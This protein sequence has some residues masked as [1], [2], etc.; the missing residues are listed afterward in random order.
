MCDLNFITELNRLPILSF[1]GN[2][3]CD[4]PV[5]SNTCIIQ[6]YT[7]DCF[8]N[9]FNNMSSCNSFD[10]GDCNGDSFAWCLQNDNYYYAFI[11]D[12]FVGN[13]ACTNRYA[14]EYPNEACPTKLYRNCFC[15][16]FMNTTACSYDGG[17][18]NGQTFDYCKSKYPRIINWT[19]Y[20]YKK[21]L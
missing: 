8:C 17:D 10:G 2:G 18:C 14:N 16:C 21:N 15:D 12:T 11:L 13:G 4:E 6:D 1:V 7:K 9:C 5:E 3:D 20:Y 19:N